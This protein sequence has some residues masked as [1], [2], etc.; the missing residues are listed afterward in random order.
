ME[1]V[2]GFSKLRARMRLNRLADDVFDV[3][4]E[5]G[6]EPSFLEKDS[7]VRVEFSREL[8]RLLV[9]CEKKHRSVKA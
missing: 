2:I 3:V 9:K 4:V 1:K 6:T 7:P 8:K 5:G